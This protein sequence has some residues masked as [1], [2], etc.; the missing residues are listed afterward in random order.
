MSV[1]GRVAKLEAKQGACLRVLF[2]SE[3]AA[4]LRADPKRP[5]EIVIVLAREDEALCAAQ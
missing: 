4:A 3:A 1:K 2:E 5:G